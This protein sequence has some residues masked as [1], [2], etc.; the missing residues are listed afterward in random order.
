VEAG[1]LGD[2]TESVCWHY[3]SIVFWIIG[4]DISNSALILNEIAVK[5]ATAKRDPDILLMLIIWL[6]V[7][8]T[9]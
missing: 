2:Q 8:V 1:L 9:T 5:V 6:M 4:I 3:K 7:S